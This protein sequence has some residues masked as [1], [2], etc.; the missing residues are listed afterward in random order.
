[1]QSV[2]SCAVTEMVVRELAMQASK[3]RSIVS[4]ICVCCHPN[5]GHSHELDQASGSLVTRNEPGSLV[6][7]TNQAL[8]LLVVCPVSHEAALPYLRKQ[9]ACAMHRACEVKDSKQ[10]RLLRSKENRHRRKQSFN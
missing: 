6:K 1:M 4:K 3:H 5:N 9:A 10:M 8:E 7:G 2:D